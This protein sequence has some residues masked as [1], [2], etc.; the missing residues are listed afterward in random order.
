MS[1]YIFYC[2]KCSGKDN[3]N[4]TYYLLHNGIF[5]SIMYLCLLKLLNQEDMNMFN[6]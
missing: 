3:T 4:K 1:I 2:S 6:W 5:S